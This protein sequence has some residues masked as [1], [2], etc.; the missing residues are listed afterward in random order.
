MGVPPWAKEVIAFHKTEPAGLR[1]PQDVKKKWLPRNQA[2][3]PDT[4][5]KA[6][7]RALC[8]RG[9]PIFPEDLGGI[10]VTRL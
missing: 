4:T 7:L 6:I 2:V 1:A 9:V 5:V 8:S 3:L 10:D